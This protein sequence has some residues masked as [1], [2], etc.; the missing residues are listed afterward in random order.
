MALREAGKHELLELAV[1]VTVLIATLC[2]LGTAFYLRFL[3]AVYKECRHYRICYLVRLQSDSLE[4]AIPD[5]RVLDVSIP[6]AA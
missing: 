4:H 2:T 6:R 5:D 1:L 3:I